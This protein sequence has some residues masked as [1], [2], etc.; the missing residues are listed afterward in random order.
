[1]V[2]GRQKQVKGLLMQDSFRS[3]MTYPTNYFFGTMQYTLEDGRDIGFCMQ[4]GIGGP[5]RIASE[6]FL[7]LDG[8]IYKLDVTRLE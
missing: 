7:T 4:D 3:R 8:K 1:M 5:D 2:D 6:D